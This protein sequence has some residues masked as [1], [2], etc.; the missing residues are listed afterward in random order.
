MSLF[1]RRLR[2]EAENWISDGLVDRGL[3]ERLIAASDRSGTRQHTAAI[4]GTGGGGLIAIGLILLV[5]SNWQLIHPWVKICTLVATMWV[6][7]GLGLRFR[8]YPGYCPKIGDGLVLLGGLLF[9]SGIALVSQIYQ[10]DSRPDRGL[11][12]WWVA[13]LALPLVTGSKPLYLG[14]LLGALIWLGMTLAEP[15]SVFYLESDGLRGDGTRLMGAQ[16]LAGSFLTGVGAYM[17][18]GR[19]RDLAG[20]TFNSGLLLVHL[21]LF[22]FAYAGLNGVSGNPAAPLGPLI[23]FTAMAVPGLVG[24]VARPRHDLWIPAAL[25]MVPVALVMLTPLSGIGDAALAISSIVVLAAFDCSL[26]WK[27][28]RTGRTGWVNLGFVFIGLNLICIYGKYLGTM[29]SGG[30]FFLVTG[31]VVLAIG[32]AVETQRRRFTRRMVDE[33]DGL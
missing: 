8:S 22:L 1:T 25:A 26:V 18:G 12:F 24:L 17:G 5:A 31:I 11:L 3:A 21:V 28:S 20:L 16:L 19:L 2:R 30:F 10:L 14:V 23:L 4:L 32:V 6:A 33:E 15:S 27:G 7:Y 29:L 9:L 13:T